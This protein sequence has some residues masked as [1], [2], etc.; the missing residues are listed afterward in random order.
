[1]HE[2]HR[3]SSMFDQKCASGMQVVPAQL[4]R[5]IA[6]YE[7]ARSLL[8]YI[9]PDFDEVA[10]V[11][12]ARRRSRHAHSASHLGRSQMGAPQAPWQ[13]QHALHC[14]RVP[15]QGACCQAAVDSRVHAAVDSGC[16]GATC[17]HAQ[18]VACPSGVAVGA[19]SQ[20]AVGLRTLTVQR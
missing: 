9:T 20:A 15:G 8:G 12:R 13:R 11:R 17:L 2:R 5:N 6:V 3:R 7:A 18:V 1:M 14:Q 10:K 4:R 16:K 19:C